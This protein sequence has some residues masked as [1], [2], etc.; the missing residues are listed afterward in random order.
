MWEAIMTKANLT[1]REVGS[2]RR[3][4]GMHRVAPGLYLRVVSP[5]AAYWMLRY[6]RTVEGRIKQTEM[7]LGPF[8]SLTLAEATAAAAEKRIARRVTGIDPLAEKHKKIERDTGGTTFEAVALTLIESKRA[9]WR[10]VKHAAQWSATLE[11]YAFPKIGSRDVATIDTEAVLDVLNPI[12]KEKHET[13]TRL[14]QRIE[15]VL[16]A[17]KVRGLRTGENP[18]A[19]R[20]HLAALLPAI[21]KKARVRH[22]PAMAWADLP[23][24]MAE[25]RDRDSISA[26]ALEFTILTACR[27]GEVIGACWPEIDL[28]AGLWII[29]GSRMKAKTEHRVPLS[30]RAVALLRSIPRQEGAELVFCAKDGKPLSNMAMLQLLRGMRDGLTV[31]GFRSTFRDW[32][33]ESTHH[34]REVIEHALAHQISNQAEAAYARGTLLDRRRR[35]MADWADFCAGNGKVIALAAAA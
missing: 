5:A 20:G 33:G 3:K 18:A 28:D 23:G 22:H 27:T 4:V 24:F 21:P 16:T 7:S 14:R 32:A 1:A 17:A 6:S 2:K 26:R 31:H 12:W 29:P 9:G 35:L 25:L 13:A 8:E 30:D 19:W 11:A 15:A 10:N 34:P